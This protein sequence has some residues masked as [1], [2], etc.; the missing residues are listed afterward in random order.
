MGYMKVFRKW[1]LLKP[2]TI[3]EACG[4][5]EGQAPQKSEIRAKIRH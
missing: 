1:V 2:D 4:I 5:L 3:F